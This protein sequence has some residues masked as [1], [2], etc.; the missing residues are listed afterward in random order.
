MSLTLAFQRKPTFR[1]TFSLD[2]DI[3]LMSEENMKSF[4]ISWAYQ[5]SLESPRSIKWMFF[6]SSVFACL[7]FFLYFSIP[8]MH[9]WGFA[10]FYL[11]WSRHSAPSLPP[12][13]CQRLYNFGIPHEKYHSNSRRAVDDFITSTGREVII[14][15][16]C[17]KT[18]LKGSKKAFLCGW[19]IDTIIDQNTETIVFLLSLAIGNI[20]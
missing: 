1:S 20:L 18:T 10:L 19:L 2:V 7:N 11:Y 5:Y 17:V 12:S 13:E 3:Y 8:L 15:N 6:S 9:S 4:G 16:Y 14:W